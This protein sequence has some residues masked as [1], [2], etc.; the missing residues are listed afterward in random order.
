ML[1]A[2]II[3]FIKNS[4]EHFKLNEFFVAWANYSIGLN[5]IPDFQHNFP[6]FFIK[7]YNSDQNDRTGYKSMSFR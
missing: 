5:Y 6:V 2:A 1:V 4:V 3:L 7:N